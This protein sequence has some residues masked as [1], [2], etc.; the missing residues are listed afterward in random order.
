MHGLRGLRS[1]LPRGPAQRLQLRHGHHL[2]ARKTRL[3][4]DLVVLATGMVSSL[5]GTRLP[6]G[7]GLDQGSFVVPD[8]SNDGIFAAGCARS[9]VDIATATQ[10]GAAAALKA[11]QA[12]QGAVRR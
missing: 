4:V 3:T 1:R 5:D 10:E 6:A 12:I 11:I 2:S 7:V 8:V 9:P